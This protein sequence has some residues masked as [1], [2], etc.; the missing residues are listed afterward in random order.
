VKVRIPSSAKNAEGWGTL[1]VGRAKGWASPRDENALH[2]FA[3]VHVS[4]VL[5][6]REC[7]AS[8]SIHCAQDDRVL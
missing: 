2:R 8:R 3:D 4:G 1:L 5:R 6:L 7:F